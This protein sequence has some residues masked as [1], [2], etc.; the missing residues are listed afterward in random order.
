MGETNW[1]LAAGSLVP[2]DGVQATTAGVDKPNGGGTFVHVGRALTNTPG[3]VALYTNQLNFAPM[4]KGCDITGALRVSQAGKSAAFLFAALQGPTVGDV[5]YLLGLSDGDPC[6]IELRKGVLSVGL[7]DETP[8]GVN[9]ILGR[10][11]LAVPRGTWRH[12][13][14]EVVVNDNGDVILNCAESDLGAHPVGSPVWAPI[15]GMSQLVDDFASIATGSPGLV[16]GHAGFAYG[17][18]SGIPGAWGSFDHI[19]IARQT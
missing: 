7:P 11:T 5:G 12:L 15:P 13:R 6:H 8:G 18:T 17:L 2:P 14:L 9:N 16:G 4:A 1:T 19:S 10:S 3:A